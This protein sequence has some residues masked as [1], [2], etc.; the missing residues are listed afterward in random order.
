MSKHE[1]ELNSMTQTEIAELAATCLERLEPG[2]QPLS[3]FAQIARLV[4]TSTVEI[5]PFESK[6]EHPRVLMARRPDDDPWWPG[7]WHLPGTV[8]LPTDGA[9][10]QHDYYTPVNRLLADE[11]RGSVALDGR[12]NMFDTRRRT[13]ARGSEQ[14]ALGW[15]NVALSDGFVEVADGTFFDARHVEQELAGERIVDG[16]LAIIEQAVT[17]RR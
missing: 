14:T 1:L 8:L 3:L 2:R 10:N 6:N 15:A 12:L 9:K 7:E 4:V 17:H 11:F 16:H 13:G 5:V